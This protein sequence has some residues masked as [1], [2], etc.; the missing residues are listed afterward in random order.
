MLKK[1]SLLLT[2]FLHKILPPPLTNNVCVLNYIF[3]LSPG[4]LIIMC[5]I[6]TRVWYLFFAF[7]ASRCFTRCRISKKKHVAIFR[8]SFISYT[9]S[10]IWLEW[11]VGMTIHRG[12]NLP[13]S[14]DHIFMGYTCICNKSEECELPLI[15]NIQQIVRQYYI[16]WLVIIQYVYQ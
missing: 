14:I 15:G 5:T 16:F 10:L 11:D 3:H 7:N 13:F 4:V 6:L 8:Y 2:C 1:H 9:F 12:G